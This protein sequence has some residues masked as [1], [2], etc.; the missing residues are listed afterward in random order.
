MYGG[1]LSE[2]L[3]MVNQV[4]VM[5]ITMRTRQTALL[6]GFMEEWIELQHRKK[7]GKVRTQL[8]DAMA[9]MSIL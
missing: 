1:Q 7:Y 8:L 9:K 3:N 4:N 2:V 6:H 5:S